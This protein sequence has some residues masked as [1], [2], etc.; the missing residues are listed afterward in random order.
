MERSFTARYALDW[1]ARPFGLPVTRRGG[2]SGAPVRRGSR[3]SR[4]GALSS[5]FASAGEL[6]RSALQALW[7]RRGTRIALLAVLAALPLCAGGYMLLRHSSFVAVQ[8]VQVSGLHGPEAPAI[9]AALV[10]AARHMSTLDVRDGTLRA[11]VA[12]FR[13]VREVKAYPR[14]P[15]GLLVKVVEELPVAALIAGGERTAVA[16]DGTVLG[17]AYLSSTLPTLGG[18]SVPSPGAHLHARELLGS[19][20]LLGAAP[21][22]LGKLVARTYSGPEGLTVAMHN[23]LVVYFGDATRAHAKWLSLAAVLAEKSSAGALY[24]DVRLPA[25]PAAGFAAGQGPES[26]ASAPETNGKPES[27]VGALAAGLPGGTHEAATSG[28]PAAGGGAESKEAGEEKSASESAESSTGTSSES[29][30]EAPAPG[31]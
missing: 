14:F 25:R 7:A 28:E 18:W 21:S 31:G 19:L 24:V 3:A 15:H 1:V 22:A 12:P 29:P 20:A 23:G 4:R 16:A 17:P 8:H 2:R 26:E 5:P 11:A 9:K 30:S 10:A 13:L 27:T 6:L